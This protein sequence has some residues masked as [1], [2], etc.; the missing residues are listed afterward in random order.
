MTAFQI[1][2]EDSRAIDM[3]LKSLYVYGF[4]RYSDLFGV[5][6]ETGFIYE[7]YP[8]REK[9]GGEFVF[10]TPHPYWFDRVLEPDAS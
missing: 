2:P 4:V 9:T 1:S 7:L 8:D 5:T 10:C 6:R 3:G